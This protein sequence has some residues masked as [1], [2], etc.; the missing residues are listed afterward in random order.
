M[1]SG[2]DAS[3]VIL[4]CV[5]QLILPTDALSYQP[6][7]YPANRRSILPTDALSC[8]LFPN[9][10]LILPTAGEH[11]GSYDEWDRRVSRH[12]GLRH[13]ALRREGKIFE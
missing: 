7:P 11:R 13:A 12:P 4:V 3:A 1:T 9:R 2:I 8:N 10:R 6:T 5:T